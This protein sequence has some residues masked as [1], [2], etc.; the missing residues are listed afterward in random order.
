MQLCSLSSRR[1]L[2]LLLHWLLQL[3]LLQLL[4]L[5]LLLLQNLLAGT[6]THLISTIDK[7]AGRAHGQD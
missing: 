7:L 3:L 5:L 6:S 2:I 1:H 4:L